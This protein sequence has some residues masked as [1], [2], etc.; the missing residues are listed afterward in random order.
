MTPA[1]G[2]AEALAARIAAAARHRAADRRPHRAAG[3]RQVD[4]GRAAAGRA[5]GARPARRRAVA[6]RPLP[7]QGRAP[8]AGRARSIRCFATRGVPGT[9]DV[10][11][12]VE[13]LASLGAARET[14]VPRF[15]KAADDRLPAGRVGARRGPGRRDRLRGLVRRRPPAAARGAGGAGQRAG[16][17]AR[18]GRRLA[19]LRQRC[20]RRALSRAVRPD[21]LPGAAAGAR[22][23]RGAGLARAAG[24]RADRPR[25]R[26]PDRRRARRLRPVLR[27][28][29]PLDRRRDA[30]E[31]GRDGAA[32]A[33]PGGGGGLS[34]N[35][36]FA[37]K[38]GPRTLY[39]WAS[40]LAEQAWSPAFARE[41]TENED[42]EPTPRSTSR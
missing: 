1:S 13:V 34:P 40:R 11:L 28:P 17:D 41:R 23:R 12:G 5:G 24:T 30:G 15:D 27:A 35:P 3:L 7:D 21:R 10:A 8:A 42:P 6:R 36:L 20:A 31:G 39:R 37:A 14:L 29:H 4:A 16:A 9:H 26:R 19:T 25:R 33:G 2:L 38:R 22:L 32:G 18:S